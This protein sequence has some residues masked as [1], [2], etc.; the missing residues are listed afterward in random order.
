MSY[1]IS[2]RDLLKGLAA[3]GALAPLP[4]AAVEAGGGPPA[5]WIV[6]K[7]TGAEALTEALLLEETDVVFGIPGAQDNEL[8]DTFKTKGLPY[9]LVTHEFSASTMADGYARATGKVG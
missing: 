4:A 8:W 7:M 9:L 6:G 3:A 1:P 5:G 2:R